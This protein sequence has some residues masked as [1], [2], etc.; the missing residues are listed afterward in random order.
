MKFL[1]KE[2][3]NHNHMNRVKYL[4]VIFLFY[5]PLELHATDLRSV[6]S[7]NW[8]DPQVWNLNSIPGF[9][10]NVLVDSGHVVLYDHHS[11]DAV[12][13]VHIRGKLEFSR[14]VNTKLVAGM[15]IL[16]TGENVNINANCSRAH[17]GPTWY[18]GSRPTMEVGTMDYPI[19]SNITSLI[20]LKYFND[21]DPDCAPGIICYGGRMDFHGAPINITWLKLAATAQSGSNTIVVEEPVDWKAGD[22]IIITGAARFGSSDP[23][24]YRTNL[25]PETEENYASNVNG[26][27]ITLT[28]PLQKSHRGL[29]DYRCEVANLSRNVVV[30]SS[31]P[32]G[33]RGHTMYHHSSLGS[34]SYA[35]FAHL[36]K[37]GLLARYPIHYHVMRSTNRGSSVIGA[38]IWDSHNRFVTIHGTNYVV[39]KDCIGYKSVGNGFFMEDASEVYNLMDHNLSVHAYNADPLPNQALPYDENDGAGFWFANGLN[40][41][42]NN[43][44]V[45]CDR[46]GFQFDI[47]DD[48]FTSILQ[49]DGTVQSTVRVE[50][51]PFIRFKNNESHGMLEYGYWGNGN[52]D[53]DDPFIME[54]FLIWRSRRAFGYEGNNYYLKNVHM[55]NQT[56]AF[57]GKHPKN[58]R[59]EGMILKDVGNIAIDLIKTPEGLITFENVLIDTA[60]E[61]PIAIN[62]SKERENACDL[63]IRNY[64]FKNIENNNHGARSDDGAEP[65]PELTLYLHDYFGAGQDAKVIPATQTR[66]DG[67]TYQALTPVFQNTVRVA[68]T[69]VP[70]PQ[71][72]IQLVDDHPPATVIIFPGHESIFPSGTSEIVVKGTC[73]DASNVSSVTVNGVPAS[74]ME[75]N[76]LMWEVQ[77]ANLPQGQLTLT[78]M[79]T[80]EFGNQELDPHTINIGIGTAAT[81]LD[82]KENKD[83]LT[84]VIKK[85]ELLGNFPNP[86]NPETVIKFRIS[87]GSAGTNQVRILVYNAF[88]QAIRRLVNENFGIGEHEVKWNGRNDRG[89]EVASGLYFYE[90]VLSNSRETFRQSRKMLLLR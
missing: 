41:F 33:I 30:K 40:A 46:Y 90:M 69:S 12:R 85:Y 56:Y 81:D 21:M 11:N 16:N 7:G 86:F 50:R 17:H 57:Y 23:G 63:H 80:D 82:E 3:I 39:V 89:E 65:S 13:L 14:S 8:S 55:W 4:V 51:L 87:H 34:I 18:D 53:T 22:H 26:N 19:P 24:S 2:W 49:P 32:N 64:T 83:E 67:L 74:A 68:T 47:R 84:S 27:T 70:F 48:I 45:E 9:G 15:I 73:I 36:G 77:L 78:A 61:Y 42:L 54:N 58:T 37:E 72:P 44:A 10:D 43:V 76:Y 29:G 25:D 66:N 6:Q 31:D 20:E 59:V 79:A 60:E 62:G 75:P 88:G 52:A 5:A 28:S 1:F 38:S 71:N 35:E